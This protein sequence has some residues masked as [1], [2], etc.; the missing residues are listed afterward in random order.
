MP[1]YMTPPPKNPLARLLAVVIAVL[2]LAGI[3]TIGLVALVIAVGVGL[4]FGI[5]AWLRSRFFPPRRASQGQA[6]DNVSGKQKHQ[7]DDVIE[8]EYT[9]VSRDSDRDRGAD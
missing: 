7:Q 2:V 9:V 6:T 8:A 5:V 3:F 1:V 4:V